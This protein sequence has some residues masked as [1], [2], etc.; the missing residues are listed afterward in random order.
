MPN[1]MWLRLLC[2]PSVGGSAR[3]F[4]GW[5][6]ELGN[7]I[8]VL[9]LQPPGRE[10]EEDGTHQENPASLEAYIDSLSETV[11]TNLSEKPFIV[12]GQGAGSFIAVELIWLFRKRERCYP[13]G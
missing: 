7:D 11:Q 1:T 5:G 2:I 6:A 4:E 8:D 12:F 10:H 3:D 13:L 9:A